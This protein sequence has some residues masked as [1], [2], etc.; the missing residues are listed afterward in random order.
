[1]LKN[2][3]IVNKNNVSPQQQICFVKIDVNSENEE[4]IINFD[5]EKLEEEEKECFDNCMLMLE[6]KI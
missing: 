6:S 4:T 5:Y 1:M 3:V 2:T